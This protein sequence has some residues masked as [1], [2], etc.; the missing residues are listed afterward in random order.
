MHHAEAKGAANGRMIGGAHE[1]LDLLRRH[2]IAC[3]LVTN[4]S[5]RSAETVLGRHDLRFDLVLT[6]DDGTTKPD[7]QLFL[8]ALARLRVPPEEAIVI[9]DAH[10]DLLAARAAGIPGVILVGTPEWM[11]AHIPETAD[12]K[13]ARDLFHVAEIVESILAGGAES[14]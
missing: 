10:L 1:L 6:R 9:G 8:D 11:R 14:D 4:N 3:A 13:E 7:P 5:R 12:H 2:R